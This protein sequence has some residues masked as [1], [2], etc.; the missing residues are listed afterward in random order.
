MNRFSVFVLVGTLLTGG[1]AQAAATTEPKSGPQ[2]TA[3]A[4]PDPQ[5]KAAKA[6]A[7][8]R[9]KRIRA[10]AHR[11]AARAKANARAMQLADESK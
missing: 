3:T 8:A 7:S 2:D 6:A 4:A 5:A 10:K 9:Y 11:N 1:L